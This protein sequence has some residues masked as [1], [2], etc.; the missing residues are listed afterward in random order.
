[1]SNPAGILYLCPT[2]IGDYDDIT[3]RTVKTLQLADLVVCESFKETSRL[4]NHLSIKKEMVLLN[5]HNEEEGVEELLAALINGKNLALVSDCGTPVFSDPGYQ[6][7][8]ACIERK[9]KI[10]P[11]PG[12]NSLLPAIIASGYKPDSFYYAGWLSP[13]KEIRKQELFRLKK[14]RSV[15]IML[16]TPYRLQRILADVADAFPPDTPAV[17]AY[18]LTTQHEEF[19]RGSIEKLKNTAERRSLKGEFVLLVDNRIY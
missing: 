11:L 2:P 4:L 13:K 12:A 10:V 7:V 1:M 17:L 9:I 15:L 6:L 5:E 19:F 14:V 3:L 16:E 8:R 18:E